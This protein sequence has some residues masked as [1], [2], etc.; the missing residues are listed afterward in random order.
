MAWFPWGFI[1][2]LSVLT[3]VFR[4]PHRPFAKRMVQV[5]VASSAILVLLSFLVTLTDNE[6]NSRSFTRNGD[7]PKVE[8]HDPLQPHRELL[9]KYTDKDI[10]DLTAFLV[11]VK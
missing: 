3:A 7:T 11:T 10:H 8:V 2:V 6:G 9:P 1:A 5:A 4:W